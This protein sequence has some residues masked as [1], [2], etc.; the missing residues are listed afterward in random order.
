MATAWVL[1]TNH[2]VFTMVFLWHHVKEEVQIE[3]ELQMKKSGDDHVPVA[4]VH[5]NSSNKVWGR[6][7]QALKRRSSIIWV[8]VFM[9]KYLSM[10]CFLWHHAKEE[11][12]LNGN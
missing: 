11:V 12:L 1:R 10:M 3:L 5:Y 2:Y 9:D 6:K 4:I 7:C 8:H